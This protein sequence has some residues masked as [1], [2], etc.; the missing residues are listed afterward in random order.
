MF[1]QFAALLVARVASASVAA[2][3]LL[4]DKSPFVVEGASNVILETIK[5]GE[6]DKDGVTTVVLRLYEAFGGHAK[7]QLKIA[8]QIPVA[9][10]Y[11]TN[12]LEDDGEALQ[13]QCGTDEEQA[14]VS[15]ALD[16]H[17][18]EVKTVKLY[19]GAAAAANARSD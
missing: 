8:P 10:A 7:A 3:P 17:S 16:F 9:K 1:N 6:D 5:R 12:L 13:I 2:A 18:F 4:Q 15:L 14:D 11:I 19:I